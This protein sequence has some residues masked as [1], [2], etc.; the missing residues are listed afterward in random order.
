VPHFYFD[1]REGDSF[2]RNDAGLEF[3][4]LDEAA[5]EAANSA[6]EIGRDRLPEGQAPEIMV[7]VRDEH[8]ERVL[9]V[10]VSMII[11]REACALAYG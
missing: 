6:A 5:A 1:V 3:D 4:S 9:T 11:R 8:G 7:E 10:T 2:T